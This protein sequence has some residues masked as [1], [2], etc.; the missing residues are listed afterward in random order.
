M[1]ADS[2]GIW[3][4]EVPARVPVLGTLSLG[5]AGGALGTWGPVNLP[6]AV[7]YPDGRQEFFRLD[8]ASHGDPDLRPRRSV[9]RPGRGMTGPRDVP[10]RG[11]PVP[12]TSSREEI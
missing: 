1:C 7:L 6:I 10:T 2:P 8:A 11:R 12:A 9:S 3:P 4:A 5:A